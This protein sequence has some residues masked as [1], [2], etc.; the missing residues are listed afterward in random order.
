[1]RRRV[2]AAE[3]DF[4]LNTYK[5]YTGK[6]LTVKID[7]LRQN[8]PYKFQLRSKNAKGWSSSWSDATVCST[9]SSDYVSLTTLFR[10]SH[11]AVMNNALTD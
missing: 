9:T 11:S 5:Q 1:M 2:E 6:D 7:K 10:R 3:G 4:A 8:L